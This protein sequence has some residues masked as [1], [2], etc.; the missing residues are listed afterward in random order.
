MAGLLVFPFYP[1]TE[2]I[3]S[4]EDDDPRKIRIR[5][6][7]KVWLYKRGRE[8]KTGD[9]EKKAKTGQRKKIKQKK[10]RKPK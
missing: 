10:K 5:I 9:G 7:L 4:I 2:P 6:P 3:L 1:N 8:G